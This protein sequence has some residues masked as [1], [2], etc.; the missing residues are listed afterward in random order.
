MKKNS[1]IY[2]IFL[3]LMLSS[4]KS[5]DDSEKMSPRTNLGQRNYPTECKKLSGFFVNQQGGNDDDNDGKSWAFAFKTLQKAINSI[6]K[7]GG[8]IY[9]ATPDSY[10]ADFGE[11]MIADKKNVAIIGGYTSADECEKNNIEDFAEI[12][13]RIFI[14]ESSSNISFYNLSIA[15]QDESGISLEGEEDNK[16]KNISFFNVNFESQLEAK[17]VDGLTISR[18][19]FSNEER[20]CFIME[21]SSGLTMSNS[22]F[23][24]CK[25][26]SNG[27]GLNISNSKTMSFIQVSFTECEA[28]QNGGA[29]HFDG[30]ENLKM[31]SIELKDNKANKNGGAINILNAQGDNISLN[32]SEKEITGNKAMGGFGGALFIDK[33]KEI[34]ISGGL[35][36]SNNSKFGSAIYAQEIEKLSISKATFQENSAEKYSVVLDNV[37]ES[38]VDNVVFEKNDGGALAL[39][40]GENATISKCSFIENFD[41]KQ[42]N[43][44]NAIFIGYSDSEIVINDSK[45]IGNVSKLGGAIFIEAYDFNSKKEYNPEVYIEGNTSFES[46]KSKEENGGGVFAIRA[47][48]KEYDS[49]LLYLNNGYNYTQNSSKNGQGTI[50]RVGW[51]GDDD[52]EI[53]QLVEYSTSGLKYEEDVDETSI[54]EIPE[55][56]P[57]GDE[58]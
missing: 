34:K 17:F 26:D 58:E 36:D 14:T 43:D 50:L 6:D 56:A 8:K 27:G 10:Q 19:H 31:A 24:N 5:C 2:L 15:K 52:Y 55:E 37:N 4:C 38:E 32:F 22:T 1:L 45:F 33:S 35:F 20:S 11:F 30:V 25:S 9:L 57:I 47:F 28:E 53:S 40:A 16:L 21:N 51:A 42:E 54:T 39:I 29:M 48:A 23:D 18:S 49:P 12:S 7:N 13:S 3:G 41:E 46:N 44:G